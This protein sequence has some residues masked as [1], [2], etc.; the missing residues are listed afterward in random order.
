MGKQDADLV[1]GRLRLRRFTTADLDDLAALHGDPAVLRYIEPHPVPREVVAAQTL[2]EI[3]R[4]YEELSPELGY[5]A[6][7]ERHS[8]AFVGWVN[9]APPTS[10]GL[11]TSDA[12][13]T[14]LELGYR[15]C[16]KVWGRGYAVEAS[17]PMIERAFARF[18]I[19]RIVATTMTVNTGS[20]RVM[21]KLGFRHVRTFF[22]EWPDSIEGAEQGDVVYALARPFPEKAGD[23]RISYP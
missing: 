3:L 13:K 5:R 9:L 4:A 16:R 1:T 6:V 2:P 7:I 21:E 12:N 11:D 22:A 17:R 10:T 23:E 19:E 14:E 20:R 8:G 18:G 15:L